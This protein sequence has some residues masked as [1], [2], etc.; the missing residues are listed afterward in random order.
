MSNVVI[1][2]TCS[3]AETLWTCRWLIAL[4]Y[5]I[6]ALIPFTTRGVSKRRHPS[7]PDE[8]NP[9]RFVVN[10]TDSDTARIVS[11]FMTEPNER[12][13]ECDV[14]TRS[15]NEFARRSPRCRK[16]QQADSRADGNNA[17]NSKLEHV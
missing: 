13:T 4:R 17:M 6:P 16:N 15:C 5:S 1:A 9:R 2:A 12:E 3:G 10:K 7:Q 8:E 14:Q 11:E